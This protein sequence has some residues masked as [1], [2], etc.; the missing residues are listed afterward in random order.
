MIILN[1]TLSDIKFSTNLSVAF[2]LLRSLYMTQ[3]NI[4]C[5]CLL[6]LLLK[7]GM[8]CV[9]WDLLVNKAHFGLSIRSF[10]FKKRPIPINMSIINIASPKCGS[11]IFYITNPKFIFLLVSIKSHVIFYDHLLLAHFH[12]PNIYAKF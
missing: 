2:H 10:G 4:C 5:V 12:I 3:E 8:V 1:K 7:H 6:L 9:F 11:N